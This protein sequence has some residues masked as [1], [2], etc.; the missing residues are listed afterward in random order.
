[1]KVT[2]GKET[3]YHIVYFYL[4]QL[5]GRPRKISKRIPVSEPNALKKATKIK[6]DWEK[7][8]AAFGASGILTRRLLADVGA[9]LGTLVEHPGVTLQQAAEFYTKHNLARARSMLVS[10][11][12]DEYLQVE[13]TR[14]TDP[15]TYRQYKTRCGAMKKKFGKREVNS[16]RGAELIDWVTG[17]AA[18]AV[19]KW[20]YLGCAERVLG[21]CISERVIKQSPITKADMKRMPAKKSSTTPDILT[22]GQGKALFE[23]FPLE[24]KAM[25]CVLYFTGMRQ[26]TGRDLVWRD[27]DLKNKLITIPAA[28]D[29]KGKERFVEG[30]PERMWEILNMLPAQDPDTPV[31]ISPRRFKTMM[32]KAKEGA[33]LASW[34]KNALRRSFASHHL[35]FENPEGTKDRLTQ[36]LLIMCHTEKPNVFWNSYFR[37]SRPDGAATYFDVNLTPEEKGSLGIQ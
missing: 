33:G 15:S 32:T 6:R 22:G 20:G 5:E 16:L 8:L 18:A 24:G 30:M 28:A 26:E 4:P 9:A 31:V 14:N 1:M 10:D 21:Y 3:N 35:N 13:K 7:H 27:V 36:T 2:L 19:T 25:F 29:K 17:L 37:R 23:S 34:P 12:I 11:A